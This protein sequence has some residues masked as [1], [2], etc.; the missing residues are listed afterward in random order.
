MNPIK[1]SLMIRA[2]GEY[3]ISTTLGEP[4]KAFVSFPLPPAPRCTRCTTRRRTA[5]RSWRWRPGGGFGSGAVRGVVALQ[6][7]SQGGAAD[8]ADGGHT[9]DAY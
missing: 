7:D 5:K 2:A 4:V 6:R 8:F 9:S 1:A 3:A